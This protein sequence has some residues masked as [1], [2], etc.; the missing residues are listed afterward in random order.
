VKAIT[1]LLGKESKAF[2]RRKIQPTNQQIKEEI[3]SQKE[4]Y[5]MI[6]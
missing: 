2:K 6:A 5:V 4:M 3:N 1:K